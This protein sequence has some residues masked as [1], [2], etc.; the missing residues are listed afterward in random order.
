VGRI[1]A[2]TFKSLLLFNTRKLWKTNPGSVQLAIVS[3]S[4]LEATA[5]SAEKVDALGIELRVK[6][7]KLKID[8]RLF[9]VFNIMIKL[10]PYVHIPWRD[11]IAQVSW[12]EGGGDTTRPRPQGRVARWFVFIPIRVYLCL[13]ALKWKMLE[14][15]FYDR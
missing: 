14:Y 4:I 6:G 8:F 1:E 11:S 15:I 10:P 3:S 9:Q 13:R 2:R 5:F 7:S 12:V